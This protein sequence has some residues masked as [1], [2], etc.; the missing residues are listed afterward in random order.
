MEPIPWSDE[1]VAIQQ[2]EFG[3]PGERVI[4]AQG[5]LGSVID[6]LA[7]TTGTLDASLV[8]SLTNRGVPPF[9]VDLREIGQLIEKRR[10]QRSGAT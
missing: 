10:H 1:A 7:R 9:Q 4:V 8:I 6:E 3:H 2:L 5:P